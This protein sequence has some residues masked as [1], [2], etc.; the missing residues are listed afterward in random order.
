MLLLAGGMRV[1][2]FEPEGLL[3]AVTNQLLIRL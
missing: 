2:A 3:T 1:A